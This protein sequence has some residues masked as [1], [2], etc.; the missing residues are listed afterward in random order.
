MTP[1]S[2]EE[3]MGGH[4]SLLGPQKGSSFHRN[5]TS[6]KQCASHTSHPARI[7]A[8]CEVWEVHCL[9]D[10]RFRWFPRCPKGASWSPKGAPRG[11]MELHGS[12]LEPPMNFFDCT[13]K[14]TKCQPYFFIFF[15]VKYY[16]SDDHI[17]KSYRSK[18]N[19]DQKIKMYEK[20]ITL[21]ENNTNNIIEYPENNNN[22]KKKKYFFWNLINQN[23]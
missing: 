1:E 8:D 17:K 22:K 16:F 5:R 14:V 11:S 3:S 7:L 9:T 2:L 23:D 18:E 20:K 13:K 6:V 21:L 12:L 10:V 19:I 4:G 15:C